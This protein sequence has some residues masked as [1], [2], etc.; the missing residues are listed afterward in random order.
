MFILGFRRFFIYFFAQIGQFCVSGGFLG[1]VLKFIAFPV[2]PTPFSL[3]GCLQIFKFS[4]RE[5][6]NALALVAGV[7]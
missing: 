5:S 2:P 3:A 7:K 6:G 1:V 4:E